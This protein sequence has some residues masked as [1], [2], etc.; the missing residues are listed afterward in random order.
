MATIRKRG[1]RWQVQIRLKGYPAKTKSFSHKGDAVKWGRATE[2][3]L[4]LGL[5]NETLTVFN[6]VRL[7]ELFSRYLKEVTAYKRGK[8]V[9][10]LRLKKVLRHPIAQTLVS[11]V[12]VEK[13][14]RYR[15][16]RL[17]EVSTSTVKRD[18]NLLHH[19]FSIAIN[20][21]GVPLKSNPLTTI[22]KPQEHAP[23]TRRLLNNEEAKLIA[24]A[25]CSRTEYLKPAIILALETGMRRGELLSTR[26][27][28]VNADARLLTIRETKNGEVRTIPLSTKAMTTITSLPKLQHKLFNCTPNALQKSWK[29][30]TQH[31]NIQDLHFH[32]L[33][34]EAISRFFECGLT[35]PE[36]ALISGHKDYRMLQRYTHLRPEDLVSKLS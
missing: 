31:I 14:A 27:E 23:R 35:I 5:D 22:R 28:D 30:L 19:V 15:D 32:D 6:N 29:R 24:E 26:W 13:F 4:L 9:E 33:R 2:T 12:S 20:E 36:V 11:E 1:N 17:R 34:H 3:N 21:W 7:S 8:N 25:D 10:E 18:L 16:E